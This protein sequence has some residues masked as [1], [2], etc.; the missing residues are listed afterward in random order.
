MI[1]RVDNWPTRLERVRELYETL[2]F[3]WGK[4]DCCC[5]VSDCVEALTSV[6]ISNIHK[7]Y[8]SR[9]EALEIV[10]SYGGMVKMLQSRLSCL[11][12]FVADVNMLARGDIVAIDTGDGIAGGVW[13]GRYALAPLPTKGLCRI[14][15][16]MVIAAWGII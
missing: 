5:F 1:H 3:K 13:F 4:S 16:E 9:K 8:I 2:P 15:K 7:G 10:D 14:P 11:C 12:A 6:N